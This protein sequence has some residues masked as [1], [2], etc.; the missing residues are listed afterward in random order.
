MAET[1]TMKLLLV[2]DDAEFLCLLA[3]SLRYHGFSVETTVSSSEA[4]QI[5]S[6]GC[7]G[8]IVLDWNLPLSSGLEI[9]SRFRISGGE[10]PIIFVSGRHSVDDQERAFEAGADD[11]LKKPFDV[12]E[13]VARIKSFARRSPF[14]RK[15]SIR[16]GRALLNPS[17]RQLE[18]D[19]NT[20]QLSQVEA[21]LLHYLFSHPNQPQRSS[22]LRA[23]IWS[24]EDALTDANIRVHMNQLRKKLRIA[25]MHD[26]VRTVHGK[27]Y[28]VL[29]SG[30]SIPLEQSKV[31]DEPN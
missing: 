14:G 25:G 8:A 3:A 31:R 22:E 27:G 9:C 2:D 7:F 30:T 29:S 4:L 19:R 1:T 5:I 15:V 20:V 21:S 11:Y 6:T 28:L 10:T 23:N 13:L 12:R 26:L 16:V 17:T 18:M 24:K